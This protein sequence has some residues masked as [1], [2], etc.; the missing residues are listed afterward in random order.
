MIIPVLRV[1]DPHNQTLSPYQNITILIT[2]LNKVLETTRHAL[3]D[4]DT[5]ITALEKASG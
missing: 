5:R 4:L 3:K 1:V 2:E